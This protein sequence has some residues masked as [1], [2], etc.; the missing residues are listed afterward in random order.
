MT[1][2]ERPY[3]S[4]LLRVW[5]ENE[6]DDW[7]GALKEVRTGELHSFST[8]TLLVEFLMQH[9]VNARPNRPNPNA[10]DNS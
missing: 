7:R 1:T 9:E 8:P 5:R 6:N 2:R 4:Y 3:T 10:G